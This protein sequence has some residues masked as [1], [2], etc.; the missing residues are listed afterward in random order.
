ML[1]LARVTLLARCAR[2]R[3][4][5]KACAR[6]AS[7]AL[8]APPLELREYQ[9]DAVDAVLRGFQEGGFRRQLLSLPT[10]AGK[11]VVFLE[12]ARQLKKKTLVITNRQE[13]VDQTLRTAKR[14]WADA[15]V[16]IV[17]SK[18][19]KRRCP[20]NVA[21]TSVQAASHNRN[22]EWFAQ[23]GFELL[24]I[25]EAHHA[26]ADSYVMLMR[27]AGFLPPL[28][29][30]EEEEGE[31]EEGEEEEGDGAGN[32]TL[33]GSSEWDAGSTIDLSLSQESNVDTDDDMAADSVTRLVLGVTA[34]P[35]RH[36]D[37]HQ[38]RQVFEHQA[39]EVSM[40][41]LIQAGFLCKVQC[42]RVLTFTDISLVVPEDKEGEGL[43]DF[44]ERELSKVI[45]NLARNTLVAESY[46][47]IAKGRKAVAFCCSVQH[48]KDLTDVF[49]DNGVRAEYLV[50]SNTA[51]MRQLTVE[52]HK[53]GDFDVLVNVQILTEG[54][55]DTSIN[56]ILMVRPTRSK[57][58]YTQCIGR[59]LRCHPGKEDCIVI[60][61]TDRDHS[62]QSA[63]DLVSA[64]D[65]FQPGTKGVTINQ[66]EQ[67]ER[68]ERALE[69]ILEVRP[70]H[71]HPPIPA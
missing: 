16:A 66:P 54:Y 42:Y 38:L 4:S 23:Q 51:A 65:V 8:A 18:T 31:E 21:I 46:K 43:S 49:N 7:T 34:T 15:D 52:R 45:N 71:L 33:D 59:G 57:G 20:K 41:Q 58:L 70:P 5:S 40:S 37:P 44:N 19:K 14:V 60:D 48:A 26:P 67:K 68:H 28:P 29:P 36:S 17:Q 25:D 56:C 63:S 55:D 3:L 32:S 6:A 10:G 62:L 47:R 12:I 39:F 13:L 53:R 11:T 9:Q 2:P 24:I 35:Y 61:F 22:I 69:N 1:H 30:A 50:G 64:E 27:A